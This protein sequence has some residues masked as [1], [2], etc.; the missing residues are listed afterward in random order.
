[1]S[2]VEPTSAPAQSLIRCHWTGDAFV[3][4]GESCRRA[5]AE[6]AARYRANRPFPHI[7]IE[8][9]VD[10]RVLD[11]TLIAFDPH[12]ALGSH[13]FNRDQERLKTQ[14]SPTESTDPF[15]R[16]LFSEFNSA[17]FLSFLEAMTGIEGLLPDPYFVG[18]GFHEIQRGGKLDVHS[19]FNIHKRLN[20]VRRLNLLIYLNKDWDPSYGGDLELWDADMTKCQVRVPPV[21]NRAVIF[22][23]DKNSLHGHPDPLNCPEGRARQSIA[24]Y[25]Y[26][27]PKEGV[28]ALTRRTTIFHARPSTED[29]TDWQVRRQHFLGDWLPPALY[30]LW[31][32]AER[33]LRRH[34]SET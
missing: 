33:K 5:G 16:I 23:T 17:N 30:R 32:R 25:Y 28:D 4:D 6:L 8:N 27:S 24:L 26:T 10:P 22:S 3:I 1:M 7:V 15:V 31:L 29:K 18:G 21:F 19:D 20:L 12:R 34:G 14:I 2:V 9:F 13:T 11:R